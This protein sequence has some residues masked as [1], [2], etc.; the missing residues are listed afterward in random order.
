MDWYFKFRE[1]EYTR[2]KKSPQHDAIPNLLINF[3]SIDRTEG[4]A[5]LLKATTWTPFTLASSNEYC[6]TS[7]QLK[8]EIICCYRKLPYTLPS[9][10]DVV[11]VRYRW[12]Y[13]CD[14]WQSSAFSLFS[15][16]CDYSF[17]FVRRW[18]EKWVASRALRLMFWFDKWNC[19]GQ[20]GASNE[21]ER[22]RLLKKI[23]NTIIKAEAMGAVI[24]KMR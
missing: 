1:N 21:T 11:D 18:W 2:T 23:I 9:D 5:V 12:L 8:R 24:C 4:I 6:F 14:G 17:I 15:T 7:L 22:E 3:E 16:I 10:N 13:K 19:N 20:K